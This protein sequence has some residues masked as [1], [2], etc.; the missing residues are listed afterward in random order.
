MEH[1][2]FTIFEDKKF[3][4]VLETLAPRFEW[5]RHKKFARMAEN[6]YY[7]CK[8]S[9]LKLF[10]SL[11][12]VTPVRCAIDTLTTKDQHHSY[13]A[14]VLHWIDEAQFQYKTR[15]VAFELIDEV[16]SGKALASCFWDAMVERELLHRVFAMMGNNASNNHAMDTQLQHEYHDI[17]A[18]WPSHECFHHCTCHVLCLVVK[19][20]L[21]SMV[22]STNEDYI[23]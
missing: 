12:K 23:L 3:Q 11:P 1:L 9:M 15:L 13:M 19:D 22:Q 16:H 10:L 8:E 4:A 6:L 2:P 5:P 18:T 21:N 14:I 7:T 20:F 17:G